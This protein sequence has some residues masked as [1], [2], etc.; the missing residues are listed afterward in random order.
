[1][2]PEP[3]VTGALWRPVSLPPSPREAAHW[4]QNFY[5]PESMYGPLADSHFLRAQKW[6]QLKPSR[7]RCLQIV[8]ISEAKVGDKSRRAKD[9]K[10]M[11]GWFYASFFPFQS[12]RF[13]LMFLAGGLE[14]L[15][16]AK[17]RLF[18]PHTD[19][20]ITIAGASSTL[21]NHH[22]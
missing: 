21:Y 11:V 18:S 14:V 17:T 5:P 6:G 7:K 4:S 13:R 2:E 15:F 1:M 19:G 12:R 20:A 10:R 22:N 8:E 9:Q 16:A 3:P